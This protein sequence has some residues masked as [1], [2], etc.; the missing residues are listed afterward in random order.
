[1]ADLYVGRDDEF[2][3]RGRKVIVHADLEIGGFFVD[4]DFYGYENKCVHQG[5]PVC[6]VRILNRV[7]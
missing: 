4:G 3:D 1:M 7:V 6:Q 2:E 5:G